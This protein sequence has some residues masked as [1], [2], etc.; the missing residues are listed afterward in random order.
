M[1]ICKCEYEEELRGLCSR[2]REARLSCG[3]TMREAGVMLGIGVATI[4][5][6][7]CGVGNP[8]AGVLIAMA[9]IYGCRLSIVTGMYENSDEV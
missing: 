1:N 8:T 7:E 9:N 2:L 4:S 3:M 6:I 5:R